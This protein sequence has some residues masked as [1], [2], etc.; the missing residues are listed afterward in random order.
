MKKRKWVPYAVAWMCLVTVLSACAAREELRET[1]RII[2]ISKPDG[3]RYKVY[4]EIRQ[5]EKVAQTE[6]LLQDTVKGLAVVSMSREA[7]YQLTFMNTIP[8]SPYDKVVYE[9]W[10]A[11]KDDRVEV[12]SEP[13][14]TYAQLDSEASRSI[15]R[16]VK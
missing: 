3:D 1:D 11:P 5:P 9:V 14:G 7:D 4:K 16:L 8:G 6:K 10:R 12:V 2:Q 13:T 15:L